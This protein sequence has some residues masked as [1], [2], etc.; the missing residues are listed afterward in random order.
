MT[1]RH[2]VHHANVTIAVGSLTLTPPPP[3]P[4]HLDLGGGA[5]ASVTLD[6]LCSATCGDAATLDALP[7]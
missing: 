7:S 6:E 3:Q 5:F 1:A 4:T 2:T